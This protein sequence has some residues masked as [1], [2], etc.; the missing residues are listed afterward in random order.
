MAS[1]FSYS[2]SIYSTTYSYSYSIYA[3]TYSFRQMNKN[4][5]SYLKGQYIYKLS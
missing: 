4:T 5:H 1:T 2:Y 3:T